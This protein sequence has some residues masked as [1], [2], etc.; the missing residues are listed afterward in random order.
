[1]KLFSVNYFVLW[2]IRTSEAKKYNWEKL[3]LSWIK[4]K[5]QTIIVIDWNKMWK[6]H[7]FQSDLW[8]L[9]S[10][11]VTKTEEQLFLNIK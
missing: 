7:I 4:F 11:G 10:I 9:T 5:V 8:T 2:Y 6:C 1:M 3:D